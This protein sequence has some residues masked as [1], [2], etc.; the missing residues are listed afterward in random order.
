MI[1]KWRRD[2]RLFQLL[3]RESLVLN[4]LRIVGVFTEALAAISF[5]FA[6]V[7]FEPHDLR[8]TFVSED[9][10]CN[11]VYGRGTSGHAR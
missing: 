6:P 3:S 4:R 2:G 7:A 5:V 10:R 11:T 9:V 8:I 1:R